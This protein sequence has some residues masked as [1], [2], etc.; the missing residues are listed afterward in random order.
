M[1]SAFFVASIALFALTAQ[2]EDLT[3]VET[4]TA[5]V[6][7][8]DPVYIGNINGDI[9]VQ[10][11][12]SQEI[13]IEYTITCDDQEEMDAIEIV[14][15]TENGISFSVDYDDDW[16]G[17]NNGR[18]DFMILAPSGTDLAYM[19]DD[20]NGEITLNGVSGSAEIDLVNGD[21]EVGEFTGELSVDVVNGDVAMEKVP[22]LSSVDI[23]N[24]SVD[25]SIEDSLSDLMIESVNASVS[26]SLRGDARVSLET[27]SGSMEIADEFSARIEND[28]VGSSSEFGEG[29]N[30]IMISTLNGDIE[31]VR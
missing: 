6:A 14:Q 4:V 11:S 27:L 24:G 25:L 19:L 29:D 5:S 9:Q 28:I 31:I 12:D 17:S 13:Q 3:S 18:V 22:G 10:G 8:G 1:R 26:L 15:S 7:P 30:R 16:E 21:V 20:V 2:A 23:V